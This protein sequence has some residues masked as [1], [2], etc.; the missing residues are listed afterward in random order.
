VIE[1][2]WSLA[3]A[4]APPEERVHTGHH[5][6]S[7]GTAAPRRGEGLREAERQGLRHV[8][9]SWEPWRPVPDELGVAEQFRFQ[10]GYR[11]RDIAAGVQDGRARARR[12]ARGLPLWRR[13]RREAGSA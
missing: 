13:A 4:A 3:A 5:R 9:V 10:P 12:R 8:L 7:I 2:G 6:R 11:N 1:Q